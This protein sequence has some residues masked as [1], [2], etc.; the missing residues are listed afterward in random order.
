MNTKQIACSNDSK[1]GLVCP[2]QFAPFM[3]NLLRPL[4]HNPIKLFRPYVKPGMTVLDV[5]C[6]AGFA[7]LGLAELV[8]EKGRVISADLQPKMLDMVKTRAFKAGFDTRIRTHVCAANSI[9][10]EEDLDFALAFFMLH[11]V[12]DDRAFLEEVYTLLKAGGLFFLTEPKIHVGK[13][14]FELAV[15]KAQSV[16]FVVLKR[17]FVRFGR[18]VLLVKS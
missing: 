3:D 9:G 2:W 17:P 18:A 14:K 6:G 11:E 13:G 4:V 7:S 8:G 12:P 1:K 5:G 10:I 16:G 15:E